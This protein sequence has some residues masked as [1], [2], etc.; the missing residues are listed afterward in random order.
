MNHIIKS[1]LEVR[2]LDNIKSY[3]F[4]L[5][6][7][8]LR[9]H[10]IIKSS[11]IDMDNRFNE[12]VPFFSLFNY[13]F[14]L[15]NRLIDVFPNQFLFYLMNRKSYLTKLNN[16]ILQVLSDPQSVIVVA[17]TSIKNQV[18]LQTQVLSIEQANEPYIGLTQ[19]N[20]IENS[21]QD[22]LPY[23]L[24]PNGLCK[25]FI[26]YPKQPCVCHKVNT[27]CTHYMTLSFH[28]PHDL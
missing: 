25:L 13:E 15:K 19:E 2:L 24:I 5:D 18:V 11:I 14:S 8:T 27:Y 26:A 6:K 23:I 22:C 28:M 20:S 3:L 12:I 9:Q 10:T 16:L 4:S 7:L 1:I 21:V 17:D